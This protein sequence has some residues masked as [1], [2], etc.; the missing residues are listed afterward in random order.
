MYQGKKEIKNDGVHHSGLK[1]DQLYTIHTTYTMLMINLP[2]NK[3]KTIE[4][5]LLHLSW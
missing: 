1:I 5:F 4:T 2:L 3:H